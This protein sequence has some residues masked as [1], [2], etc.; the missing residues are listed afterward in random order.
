MMSTSS[1]KQNFSL[2]RTSFFTSHRF[3]QDSKQR[4]TR[5]LGARKA[6]PTFDLISFVVASQLQS[7]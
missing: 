7:R 5:Y 4:T 2:F 3:A 6:S 1:Q